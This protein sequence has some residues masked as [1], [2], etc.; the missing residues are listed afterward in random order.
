M[1]SN[2]LPSEKA[3]NT[4]TPPD[5]TQMALE[6]THLAYERTLMAWIRTSAA[7]ITSGFTIYK[8][9]EFLRE[10]SHQPQHV[11]GSRH[12]GMCLIVIGI[13]TL[14]LATWQHQR[15]MKQLRM[16]F[17]EAPFSLATLAATLISGLGILALIAV[18]CRA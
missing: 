17:P 15:S 4:L 5:Q 7:L 1:E 12:Y 8:F 3:D 10:P 6:R 16:Q 2:S 11:L 13:F 18:A 9:F 14:A